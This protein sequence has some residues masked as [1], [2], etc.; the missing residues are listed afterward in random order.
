M[1]LDNG[2]PLVVDELLIV[3][4][5]SRDALLSLGEGPA[6]PVILGSFGPL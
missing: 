1:Q 4:G 6:R 2:G 3:F 5:I